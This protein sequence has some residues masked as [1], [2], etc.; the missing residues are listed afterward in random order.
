MNELEDNST[1]DNSSSVLNF[2]VYIGL[3]LIYVHKS[4]YVT[5]YFLLLFK[6]FNSY[7]DITPEYQEFL[8]YRRTKPGPSTTTAFGAWMMNGKKDS[9]GFLGQRSSA[10]KLSELRY[11]MYKYRSTSIKP[12][13]CPLE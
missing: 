9:L 2:I 3:H 7:I 11:I 5:Y 12:F 1:S 6:H 10:R 8:D 4:N 13:K